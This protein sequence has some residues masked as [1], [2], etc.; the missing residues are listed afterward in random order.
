MNRRDTVVAKALLYIV[1][2]GIFYKLI[3]F[4]IGMLFPEAAGAYPQII[5]AI[6]VVI[7]LVLAV[8]PVR[9]FFP[10]A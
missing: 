10:S 4:V 9:H 6:S 1:S 2:F 3:E 7:A 8:A 5:S